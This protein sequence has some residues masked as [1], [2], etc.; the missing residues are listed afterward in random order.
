MKDQHYYTS[1]FSNNHA[2]MLI[3][4]PKSGTI[5][6]ANPAACSY[7]G[8]SREELLSKTIMDINTLNDTEVFEEMQMAKEEKRN[9]FL[10]DHR[11]ADGTV[12]NVEVY[13]GPITV[14]EKAL[15]YSIVHDITGRM[16]MEKA[17][18]ERQKELRGLYRL[19]E[20]VDKEISPSDRW[21]IFVFSVVPESM[22]Y[23]ESVFSILTID[24]REYQHRKNE[25]TARYIEENIHISGKKRGTLIVGYT[26]EKNEFLYPYENDLV[27]GFANKI[28][29]FLTRQEALAKIKSNEEHLNRIL[30]SMDSSIIQ[31]DKER[32]IIW[33]NRSAQEQRPDIITKKCFNVLPCRTTYCEDC[34]SE[35][36]LQREDTVEVIQICNENGEKTFWNITSI[37]LFNEEGPPQE[38]LDIIRDV[39][40]TRKTEEKTKSLNRQLRELSAYL[41][42]VREEERTRIAREIHDELGQ[43]L[44]AIKLN[45]Y[46]I[47]QNIS[48]PS[49]KLKAKLEG[50][51]ELIDSSVQAVQKI[52]SELRPAVLDDLQI[53]DAIRWESE[54]FKKRTGIDCSVLIE[55]QEIPLD[56]RKS[57]TLFRIFREILTNVA[58]HAEATKVEI[59]FQLLEGYII[60]KVKDNGKGI[61]D[62]EIEGETSFGLIG[63]RERCLSC[64]GEIIISGAEGV[65]TIIEVVIPNPQRRNR[66]A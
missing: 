40:E 6:D 65:G 64:G 35:E 66:D 43:T 2:V 56:P 46:W 62:E 30:N 15:L 37:P 16:T 5:V 49:K 38:T 34:S 18:R 51:L 13:S 44:T 22:Q 53:S 7:Y 4:D 3:I 41:E 11:L 54:E 20:L 25:K 23:T 19:N 42:T 8:Y 33:A 12:R 24:N 52:I 1:L 61:T 55:P 9:Y 31:L 36:A 28:G 14:E 21:N 48:S 60:L 47:G 32:N 10:F 58:R 17:T 26:E 50:S 57:T 27:H 29:N 45:M 63:L 39:T 59:H